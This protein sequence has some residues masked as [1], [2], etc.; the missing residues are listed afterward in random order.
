[1]GARK[2]VH[3]DIMPRNGSV[4]DLRW[5]EGDPSFVFHPMNA[6]TDNNVVTCDVCQFEQALFPWADGTPGDPAKAV[7]LTR[8]EFDLA[9]NSDEFKSER[10]D[11][12]ACEFP[13]LDE[14]F[15]GTDYR[16]GF[17]AADNNPK[18]KVGGFND[19]RVDHESAIQKSTTLGRLV[20]PMS[21]YL[22][23]SQ[24]IHQR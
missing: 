10:L 20:R 14:R 6:H 9:A 15:T 19:R 4:N 16:Y 23:P 17:F 22:F 12:L 13:R 5:F 1:M 11:D 2:G 24:K 18:F 7:R 21:P 3:I 8:W